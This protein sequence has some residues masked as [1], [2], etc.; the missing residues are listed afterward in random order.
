MKSS[1]TIEIRQTLLQDIPAIVKLHKKCFPLEPNWKAQQIER[2]LQVFPQ[3]QI[4]I[5]QGDKLIATSISL[6]TEVDILNQDLS[7][8]DLTSDGDLDEHDPE[9]DTLLGVELL[10]DPDS[11]ELMLEQ[12]IYDARK[13]LVKD[14]NLWRLVIGGRI[15]SQTAQDQKPDIKAYVEKVKA[16]EAIDP[17]LTLQLQN[18]FSI[19]R[20]V[21]NYFGQGQETVLVEW[22]NIDYSPSKKKRYLSTQKVRI[23]AVQ[24]KMRMVEGFDEFAAQCKYFVDVAAGYKSDFVLFPELLTLQLLSFF[25]GSPAGLEAR[26]LSEYTE[27][28]QVLFSS[29]AVK[30]NINIIAGSHF[31]VENDQLLNCAFLFHRNGNI[32]RQE[33]IHITPSERNWWGVEGGNEIK[34]FNSDCGKVAL[35]I[36]YDVEFPEHTRIAVEKGARIVFVPFCTDERHGYLRVRYCAQARCIENQIYVAI[37]G[38]VGNL[39]QVENLDIQYAQAAILTPSDF[40]FARDGIA[41]ESTPNIETVVIHDVDLEAL[42]RSRKRGTT[43]NWKDRRLD[44]YRVEEL[45]AKNK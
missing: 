21:P 3:G 7:W 26:M 14:L 31:I 38:T 1:K 25:K 39:P 22:T 40:A 2:H 37:A 35:Q 23:C 32:D 45:S 34:V 4:S 28:Y 30:F 20:I 12:R 27:P 17:V 44:L 18:E 13:Q 6:I 10:V 8:T 33:K 36:C 19:K 42:A 29:L 41:A 43:L 24:Y 9:G 11:K 15:F 5:L 16:N